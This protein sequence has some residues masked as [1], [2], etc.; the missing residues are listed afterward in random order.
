V[1]SGITPQQAERHLDALTE[2]VSR[3]A[4]ATLAT[5]FSSV[6][7]RIK[8]DLSP[9]TAADEAS[10]AVIVEGVSRL[11]PGIA[12]IAEESVGRAAAASLEPSFV[13]VDP[14]DG[15]KEFLAGRDEFTVNVAIV[16]HGVP[17]AGLIAAPAQ[18]L[19]WRGVV[20]GKAERLRL[21]FGAGP[22]QA[23]DRSFIR[24]RPAPDRLVVA[25]SRSHLDEATEDFLARLPVAK[26]FLCGSSVKFCYLAQGEADV[27]PRLSPTHEWD[28]AAGC[29]ILAAAADSRVGALVSSS[30]PSDPRRLVSETFRLAGLPFPGPIAGPLSWLTTREFLRP[31]GHRVRDIS[32]GAAIARYRGPILLVHGELDRVIPPRHAQRLRDSAVAGRAGDGTNVELLLVPDGGHTWLYESELYRRHI[33]AFLA[34]TLG[35]PLSPEAAAEAAG[36]IM[37]KRLPEPEEPLVGSRTDGVAAALLVGAASV[38]GPGDQ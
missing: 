28:I 10:E 8:N 27:Y 2:I 35:G 16:T 33:A 20:G 18:G 36:A 23:Y 15:T 5:P 22:A 25:T 4:A 38:S 12:V 3:A 21:R 37:V 30:A 6:E 34:R 31:R 11:L 7:R 19:L 14:L 13:V 1:T 32:A 29:A 9:V 17:V 24:A 26:R